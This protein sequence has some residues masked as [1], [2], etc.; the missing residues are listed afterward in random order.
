MTPQKA[1]IISNTTHPMSPR[2]MTNLSWRPNSARHYVHFRSTSPPASV[3]QLPQDL[4]SKRV[5]F[6]FHYV[7][8]SPEAKQ[9]RI[10]S[11]EWP[12]WRL[13]WV[14]MFTYRCSDKMTLQDQSHVSPEPRLGPRCPGSNLD[15]TPLSTLY[16]K[17][18]WSSV[19]FFSNKFIVELCS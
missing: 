16:S 5:Y 8:Y 4:Q 9:N 17:G 7:N 6:P 10:S 13:S 3:T 1:R 11:L 18:T 2:M 12:P 19:L 14:L 15:A